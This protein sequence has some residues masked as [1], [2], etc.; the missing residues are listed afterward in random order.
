MVW[1]GYIVTKF[2][3]LPISMFLGVPIF[4]GLSKLRWYDLVT[5][6]NFFYQ[7]YACQ[8]YGELFQNQGL[9]LWI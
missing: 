9:V 8:H 7:P 5:N 1:S 6:M 3:K 4:Q 2:V